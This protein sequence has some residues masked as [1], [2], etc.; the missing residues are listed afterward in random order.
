M[1]SLLNRMLQ[2]IWGAPGDILSIDTNAITTPWHPSYTRPG[3]TRKSSL[4]LASLQKH[5]YLACKILPC[6]DLA[7]QKSNSCYCEND[8][9]AYLQ[10]VGRQAGDAQKVESAIHGG[11]HHCLVLLQCC[12]SAIHHRTGQRRDVSAYYQGLRAQ[13][14]QS[15]SS[16]AWDAVHAI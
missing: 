2:N 14:D 6:T 3:M 4:I 15:I 10:E 12:Q 5:H 16:C 9:V 1:L 13:K 8:T 11:A 7:M